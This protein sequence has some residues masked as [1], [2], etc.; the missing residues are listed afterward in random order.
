M[1]AEEVLRLKQVTG[2]KRAFMDHK[3]SESWYEF[4]SKNYKVSKE[5]EKQISYLKKSKGVYFDVSPDS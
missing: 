5:N 3:F 2:L 4:V 1:E